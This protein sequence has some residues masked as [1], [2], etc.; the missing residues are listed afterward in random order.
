MSKPTLQDLSD[1]MQSLDIAMM[2]TR[3]ADGSLE[4]RPMSNNKDVEYS[5]DSYFFT[6]DDKR[7][8]A[9]L[10]RDPHVCLAYDGRKH[11]LS[12]HYYI[13]ISGR[14]RLVRGKAEMKAHW[15]PELDAWFKQG[16]D[17]PGVVMIHVQAEHV[18]YWKGMEEGEVAL[19]SSAGATHAA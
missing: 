17:T 19:P 7:V 2:T 4:S 14:G 11:L 13:C 3:N 9:D 18:R 1:A 10:E 6:Y 15:S 16:V 12:D 5:G 8:V